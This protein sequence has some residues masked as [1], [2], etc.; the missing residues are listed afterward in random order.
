MAAAGVVSGKVSNGTGWCGCSW[1]VACGWRAAVEREAGCVDLGDGRRVTVKG[2]RGV[3]AVPP[4]CW[5]SPAIDGSCSQAVQASALFPGS[6]P[7][8]GSL[9]GPL[10]LFLP[11]LTLVLHDCSSDCKA[12]SCKSLSRRHPGLA[13]CLLSVKASGHHAE[14][15]TRSSAAVF[16][17]LGVPFE[18]WLMVAGTKY[19]GNW[20]LT[21]CWAHLETPLLKYLFPRCLGGVL[22]VDVGVC[23]AVSQRLVSDTLLVG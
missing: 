6:A 17:E 3:R 20:Q 14:E 12:S 16:S 22:C 1:L 2:L 19:V 23:P 5:V 11:T 15:R 4:G 13:F 10:N 21:P 7:Q 9:W 18:N 8:R